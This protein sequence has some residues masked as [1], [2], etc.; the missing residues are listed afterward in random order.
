MVIKKLALPRR[1]FLK[2]IGVTLALPLL[3]AMVPALGAQARSAAAPI[4][5]FGAMYVPHG[6]LLSQWTPASA[7]TGY[8][9]TP[10]LAPLES[11]RNQMVVISGLT[12]GPTVQNGGHAVAPASFLTGNIQPKQ[13]EGSDILGA[14]TVDQVIARAIGQ[15]TLLPS[16]EIATED[17]STS[18]GACDT[19]YSCTYMNTISWAGPT[20]PLPMETNPRAVF[21]RMFGG[22]GTPE[23]RRARLQTNRSILDAITGTAKQFTSGLGAKDRTLVSEYLDNV[24]EIERR[25][26]MAERKAETDPIDLT[27]PVGPPELYDDH[28]AVM[29][30]LMAAAF[31]GDITRVFTFMLMRDVTSRSFPHIGV[32]DPHHALSHEAN[33]RSD[34]PNQQVKFTKVNIH[35]VSMFARFADKL[36]QTRDGEGSLLDHSMLLYG[37]NMG[38]ANDHTHHPLPLVVVGGGTGQIHKAGHHIAYPNL[39]P[40]ANLLLG[41]AQKAGVTIDTF[42]QSTEAF[43]V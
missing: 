43:D 41:V 28:V 42:G 3:D 15:D 21:E 39:T 35:H 2:G 16:I 37:S 13:T 12:G 24:R 6:K 8:A 18:I 33:G 31:Q 20:T 29:F 1:T 25:I 11:F 23:Q 5:R 30:D 17:F 38:N 22:P 36:R 26:Q 10:I 34:D 9:M 4:R 7:G 14:V 27:A 40:M 19:G 32:P